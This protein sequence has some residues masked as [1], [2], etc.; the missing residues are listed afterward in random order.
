MVY[1]RYVPVEQLGLPARQPFGE[2]KA[3]QPLATDPMRVRAV[4]E[5]AYGDSPRAVHWKA[6]AR[7]A[8]LQT[9]LYEPAATPQMFIFCNQDTFAKVWEGIDREALE[10]T[11]TVAASLASHALEE[12]YMVGLQVNSFVG[13]SDRHVRLA[14]SRNP[15]QFT[16]ILENLARVRGWSG[17]PIEELLQTERRNLPW[18][19]TVVAVT[20]VVTPGMVDVIAAIRRS[21]HR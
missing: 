3:L 10:L 9:K 4:R 19:S 12:G 21:G 16:R 5:Y 17:Q 7:R 14:P 2:H 15:D 6:T 20:S 1:P 13:E 18:G 11:I 8:S